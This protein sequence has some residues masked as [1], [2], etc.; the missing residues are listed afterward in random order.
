MSATLR[1]RIEPFL[2]LLDAR[3]LPLLFAYA[4]QAYTVYAWQLDSGAPGG[5]ALLAGIGFEFISVGAI[6][7]SER[8]AGWQAARWPSVTALLFSVA[9]AVAHYG[10]RE[11]ALAVLHAGF[12]LVAY[13]YTLLMHAKPVVR[14]RENG[15]VLSTL[16]Q[17]APAPHQETTVNVMVADSGSLSKTARV[18]RLAESNGWSI[19]TAWRKVDRN[20]HLLEEV[21]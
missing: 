2:D 18:K 12:P 17:T 6:A 19:S 4:P 5:I 8:G 10:A 20:P 13:F 9:V 14:E 15:A 16:L 21:K 7:W 1:K 11:G 3:Y